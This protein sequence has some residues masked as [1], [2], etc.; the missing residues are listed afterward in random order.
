MIVLLLALSIAL[1]Q[2]THPTELVA[3][4]IAN[5]L[6]AITTPCP[7]I[8]ITNSCYRY[9]ADIDIH[10]MALDVYVSITNGITWVVPWQETADAW[11]MR[12]FAVGDVTYAVAL[13]PNG[14]GSVA[15][16]VLADDL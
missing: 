3:A 16:I 5:H 15:M 13:M 4:A 8:G 9:V 7:D 6:D 11:L 2:N 10:K 1:A 12:V 14:S